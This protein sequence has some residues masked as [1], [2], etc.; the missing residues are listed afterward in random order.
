MV[1]ILFSALEIIGETFLKDKLLQDVREPVL[2]FRIPFSLD[3]GDSSST[4]FAV[5]APLME[6]WKQIAVVSPRSVC[7]IF[8][9]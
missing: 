3:D 7:Q 8:Q 9:S 4:T 1:A 2:T 6:F 5:Y